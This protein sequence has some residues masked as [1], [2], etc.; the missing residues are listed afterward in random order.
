[1][2]SEPRKKFFKQLLFSLWGMATLIL[3]F[4]VAFLVYDMSEKGQSPL[5]PPDASA[6]VAPV[7]PANTIRAASGQREV[8]LFFAEPGAAHLRPEKR[9]LPLTEQT[10]ANCRV[11]LEALIG[12]PQEDLVP[13]V[14]PTVRVKNVFLMRDGTL[15]VDFSQELQTDPARPKSVSAEALLVYGITQTVCQD[16]LRGKDGPAVRRTQFLFEGSPMGDAFPEHLDL[17]GPVEPDP[18]WVVPSGPAPALDS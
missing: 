14:L 10:Q 8:S 13:I 18:S 15:V 9:V 16:A 6:I 5:P 3:L 12:G 4:C 1:M 2:S 7:K 17:S 11:A